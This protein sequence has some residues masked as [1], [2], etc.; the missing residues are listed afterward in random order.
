M[1][2]F[3]APNRWCCFWGPCDLAIPNYYGQTSLLI[4]FP[5]STWQ[6]PTFLKSGSSVEFPPR[7][8]R[9]WLH[10]QRL[11]FH[12]AAGHAC[13]VFCPLPWDLKNSTAGWRWGKKAARWLCHALSKSRG[14][15]VVQTAEKN[16]TSFFPI[17]CI[18]FW[19]WVGQVQRWDDE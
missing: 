8:G 12:D 7:D 13:D 17:T 15:V 1:Q 11:V 18:Y 9:N 10:R 6:E 19:K 16:R 4:S 2:W 5:R 14:S 3:C